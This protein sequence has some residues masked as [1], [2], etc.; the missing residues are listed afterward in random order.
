MNPPQNHKSLFKIIAASATGQTHL[1]NN[2]PCE[3]SFFYLSDEKRVVAIVADGAGSA[4]KAL[5]GAT[6]VAR[7]IAEIIFEQKGFPLHKDISSAANSVR[8]ELTHIAELE[9]N[10]L[11]DYHTT[12]V[13]VV[14]EK[15]KGTFFHI[16]DGAAIAFSKTEPIISKPENGTFLSQTCFITSDDWL[17]RLRFTDFNSTENVILATDGASPFLLT[18]N[19]SHTIDAFILPLIDFFHKNSPEAVSNSLLRTLESSGAGMVSRDDKTIVWILKN[20]T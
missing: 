17:E 8:N 11:R 16:G 14:M 6:F 15:E 18:N 12:I 4:K 19:N 9:G 7:R 1:A 3:D 20:Q 13:G 2:K 10:K 5:V